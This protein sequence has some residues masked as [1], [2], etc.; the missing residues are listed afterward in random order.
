MFFVR[1]KILEY[2]NCS[3][4]E[5]M[6]SREGLPDEY[7]FTPYEGCGH[8]MKEQF[9]GKQ[10]DVIVTPK[11]V[12]NSH[13]DFSAE[14]IRPNDDGINRDV[15]CSEVT[16]YYTKLEDI[17]RDWV[18][19][20]VK[21]VIIGYKRNK[22]GLKQERY[23]LA[24]SYKM[25]DDEDEVYVDVHD[26]IEKERE[27]TT[28]E[29]IEAMDKL[30]YLLK[31]LHE[32]SLRYRGSLL[33]FIIAYEKF[34]K[35]GEGS[36]DGVMRPRHAIASGV[37][38]MDKYGN[39]TEKFD[40][41]AN[42]CEPFRSLFAW[43]CG[44]DKNDIYYKAYIELMKV[45]TVLQ[46]DITKEDPRDYNGAFIRKAVCTYIASNEEYMETY[47][48]V[49]R[50]ILD[51]LG[52]DKL[53][54][55][56]KDISKDGADVS[57]I[58][59]NMLADNIATNSESFKYL[60]ADEWKPNVAAV[61]RL[62][63]YLCQQDKDEVKRAIDFDIEK[64]ILMNKDGSYF[65]VDVTDLV[66]RRAYALLAITGYLLLLEQ[67]DM[68]IR[69]IKADDAVKAFIGGTRCACEPFSF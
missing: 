62:L 1:D 36:K 19:K 30:P 45:L 49:D 22:G 7:S 67:F 38:K 29:I 27:F 46:V 25:Y 44:A 43:I 2:P 48:F 14:K 18:V 47:G 57:K 33:S 50:K 42:T 63:A 58:T 10:G 53:F 5:D 56:A 6:L 68:Q 13:G 55:V 17:T 32:G 51:L 54:T 39:L 52:A 21:E 11:M 64:G 41:A 8:M 66:G 69:V 12:A 35:S 15:H 59:L 65:I 31:Q 24:T 16:A 34:C 61:N 37:W 28:E 20:Y 23:E 9:S 4:V 3:I 26:L 40:E 60:K